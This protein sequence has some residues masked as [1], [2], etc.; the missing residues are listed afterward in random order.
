MINE[1]KK[2]RSLCSRLLMYSAVPKKYIQVIYI[3]MRTDT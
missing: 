3:A 1:S 2:I